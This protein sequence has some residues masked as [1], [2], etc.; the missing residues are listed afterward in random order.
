[1]KNQKQNFKNYDMPKLREA[2]AF[3]YACNVIDEL[4]YTLLYNANKPGNPNIPYFVYNEFNLNSM[5]D[6]ECKTEFRFYGNDIY[7]LIDVLRIPPEFTCNNGVKVDSVTATCI[8]LK[9]FAYPC[10]YADLIP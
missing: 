2:I 6:D 1:M 3:A 5:M 4:E 9:R 7:N 8:F 10:R